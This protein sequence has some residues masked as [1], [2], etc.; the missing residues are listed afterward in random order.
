MNYKIFQKMFLSIF[1]VAVFAVSAILV[2]ACSDD[3]DSEDP[4]FYIEDQASGLTVNS[5]GI[6]KTDWKVYTIRSNRSWKIT[7]DK[8]NDWLH[9]F[10]DEGDADGLFRIWVDKNKTFDVR[11]A[12]LIFTVNGQE[13]PVMFRVDQEADVPTVS[14]EKAS[15]G[16]EILG[17]GGHFKIPVTTNVEWTASLAQNDWVAIDSVKNDTVY[18]TAQ[19]NTTDDPRSVVLTAKGTGNYSSL[20]SSTVISQSTFGIIMNEHFEWMQEGST[21]TSETDYN[22]YQGGELSFASWNSAEKGHGWETV[23][24]NAGSTTPSL[25]GGHGYLKFGRTNFAGNVLSPA[26][27]GIIGTMNVRVSFK[28]VGYISSGGTLDDNVVKVLVYEGGGALVGDKTPFYANTDGT[29]NAFDALTLNAKVYP[30]SSNQEHG[31]SYNP[32][33][34]KDVTLTFDIKGATKDTRIMF[35]GGTAWGSSLKGKGQGKNRLY[36]DDVKVAVID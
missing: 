34:E 11:S 25:Y 31:A 10:A 21:M 2:T 35:V 26:F 32:W 30:N 6:T 7:Q 12:N 28:C 9:I 13:Q 17:S 20:V 24:D 36:I 8:E 22:Y 1:T 3:D 29:S 19:R 15:D 27:T 16:Y 23:M 4:Y 14:I 5:T 33:L 18:A